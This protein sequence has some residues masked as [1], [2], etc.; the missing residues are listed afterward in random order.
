MKLSQWVQ[1]FVAM[2][3]VHRRDAWVLGW[4]R[5]HAAPRG[6]ADLPGFAVDRAQP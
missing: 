3:F 2:E 6:T 4:R 1:P 5:E